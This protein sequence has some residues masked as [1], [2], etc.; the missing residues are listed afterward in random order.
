MIITTGG[1]N[2]TLDIS[3]SPGIET[4]SLVK[5][6]ISAVKIYANDIQ[7]NVNPMEGKRGLDHFCVTGN[8]NLKFDISIAGDP[9]AW[10]DTGSIHGFL[11]LYKAFLAYLSVPHDK[12]QYAPGIEYTRSQAPDDSTKTFIL[13]TS[14]KRGLDTWPLP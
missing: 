6:K 1:E 11:N 2:G 9:S 10:T 3:A 4:I 13:T 7:P 14:D 5:T 12:L 8:P